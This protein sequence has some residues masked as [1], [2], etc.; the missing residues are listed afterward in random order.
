[1][2]GL[3]VEASIDHDE[4]AVLQISSDNPKKVHLTSKRCRKLKEELCFKKEELANIE[5]EVNKIGNFSDMD[6]KRQDC[7]GRI[8]V[9]ESMLQHAEFL[10]NTAEIRL[11]EEELYSIICQLQSENCEINSNL[12]ESFYNAKAKLLLAY[13]EITT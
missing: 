5:K 9:L 8:E 11:S 13:N 12:K 3:E 2:D 4:Y 10:P 7:M 6:K 1:M